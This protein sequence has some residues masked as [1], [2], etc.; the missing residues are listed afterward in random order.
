[1]ITAL[2]SAIFGQLFTDAEISALLTDDAYLR[3]MVAVEIALAR[4]EA[5]LGIIPSTAAEQITSAVQANK[6]DISALTKGTMRSGFPIIALVQELRRIA[7]PEAGAYLH[8]GATTQDI[9]DTASVLQVRAVAKILESR[10]AEL[11]DQ[12]KRL[13]DRHRKTVMA[14][15]THGQQ[16]LPVSFGL[17]LANWVVPLV[18]HA[19]RLNEI[20]PRL[21]VVQFGGAAG[22]LAALDG[23]G[24][25]VMQ[26]L[27][28][29]LNLATPV[30]SWHVQRDGF[31]EFAGWLSLVTGSLAK[32]AQDIILLGQ[33]EIG[34]VSESAEEGRGGCRKKVI[35]SPAS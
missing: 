26:T 35:R 9:M 25:A 4:A 14:G 28:D 22:T 10:L 30:M 6:I 21:L 11:A 19:E 13:A 2:D 7:G 17:K 33:T 5:R 1:M 34:E 23:E 12:L 16:A 27:A 18:R 29:E 31:V 24:L 32:M 3:A 15:R 8:W 20:S